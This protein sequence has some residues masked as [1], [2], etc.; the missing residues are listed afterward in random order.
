LVPYL[1]W[2]GMFINVPKRYGFETCRIRYFD[3]LIAAQAKKELIVIYN[4]GL[5]VKRYLLKMARWVP[6]VKFG[7][8]SLRLREKLMSL[9]YS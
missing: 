6:I 8:R 9:N 1:K 7:R 5:S 4:T 3:E 2:E